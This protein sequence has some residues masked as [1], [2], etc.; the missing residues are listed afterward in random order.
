M[1]IQMVPGKH[2]GV[3]V[4]AVV[5][6]SPAAGTDLK[7]GDEITAV[8]RK[9]VHQPEALR[10]EITGRAI[11]KRMTL[12]VV[13]KSGT[14][15]V[16][17]A[18]AARPDEVALLRAQLVGRPA[19]AFSLPRVGKQETGTL[20]QHKGRPLLIDFWATW[21]GPCLSSLPTLNKIRQRY[22]NKLDVIGISSEGMG[23]LDEALP[24]LGIAYPVYAD[25]RESSFIPYSVQALPTLV[26]V[27]G[28]GIVRDVEVG[29]DPEKLLPS[30]NKL[31]GE[32]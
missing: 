10:S 3:G 26:L 6:G 14:R 7:P 22:V 12:T 23:T 28:N 25:E 2:G 29:A 4:E 15:A 30:I 13:G 32:L 5:P 17:V 21:C 27:D 9:E 16:V 18:P 31:T 24:S 1:G 8:D 20:A 11:G 19:P